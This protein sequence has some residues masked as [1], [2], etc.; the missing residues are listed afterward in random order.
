M[1]P[2]NQEW[3]SHEEE[4]ASIVLLVTGL[5]DHERHGGC[6]VG[7]GDDDVRRHAILG[8]GESLS[9]EV[10]VASGAVP[11]GDEEPPEPCLIDGL[12][13]GEQT[14]DLYASDEGIEQHGEPQ[15][16]KIGET[17]LELAITVSH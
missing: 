10:A 17:T 16:E 9:R 5:I 13:S 3:L 1:A 14:L 8:P 6:W 7:S 2:F 12:Y 11:L 4:D 15:G